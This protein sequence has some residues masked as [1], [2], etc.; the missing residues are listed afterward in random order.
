VPLSELE[1][2]PMFGQF[3]VEPE[4]VLEPE[5]LVF[6]LDEGVVPEEPDTELVP[7]LPVD[8]DVVAASATSAPPARSPEVRAPTATTLRKRMCMAWCLSCLCCAGPV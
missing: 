1:P 5:L 2:L 3:L 7:E 4:L 6:E 8:V